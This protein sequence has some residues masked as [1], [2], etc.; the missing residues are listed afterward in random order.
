MSMTTRG[1]ARRWAFRLLLALSLVGALAAYGGPL[2]YQLR[3]ERLFV[4]TSGSMQNMYPVGTAVIGRSVT[5]DQLRIGQVVTFRPI[6]AQEYVTHQIV[7]FKRIKEHVTQDQHSEVVPR[8]YIQTKG[9]NNPDPDPNLTPVTNVRY[10]VI[11][12][13]P[14]LGRWLVWSRT[15]EGKLVLFL[16]PFLLLFLAEVWSWHRPRSATPSGSRAP[17]PGTDDAKPVPA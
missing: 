15:L 1:T 9:T 3:G 6:G 13:Y 7:A 11:G 14:T 16:P 5:P 8:Y 12:G 10:L 4:L 2:L 17:S